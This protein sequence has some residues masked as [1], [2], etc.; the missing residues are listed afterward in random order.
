MWICVYTVLYE[1]YSYFGD[2]EILHAAKIEK[3]C[4]WLYQ[5]ARADGKPRVLVLHYQMD[6]SYSPIT[7]FINRLKQVNKV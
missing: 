6:R 2:P 3:Y 5:T 4:R 7:L 1:F